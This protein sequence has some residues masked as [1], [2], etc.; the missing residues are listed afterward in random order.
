MQY[1]MN[2]WDDLRYFLAISRHRTLKAAGQALRVDQ[3]TMGRRLASLEAG[4]EA[5]LL[6]KRSDGYF[7]TAAGRRILA[8]VELIE[9][10]TFAIDQGIAGK[11]EKVEGVVKIALPGAL[12]ND[13]ILGRL[14]PL[15]QRYPKLELQFL[16]GPDVLNLARR[17]A[18]FALRFVRPTQQELRAKKVC[19]LRLGLYG[20]EEFASRSLAAL[21]FVGLF[22]AATTQ[23]EA[24]FRESLGF[25]PRYQMRT[26]SWESVRVGLESGAGIG[27]LPTFMAAKNAR[28]TCL[29]PCAQEAPLWL[30]VHPEVAKSARVRATLEF[31][32]KILLEPGEAR[33]T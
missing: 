32:E 30:V 19:S 4:L 3:A 23:L 1:C 9:E 28:L 6:E 15:L 33:S 8:S 29:A 20:L 22:P 5:K 31:L 7:L 11:N 18:D 14:R 2:N 10:T 13:L 21:P 17:E 26:G 16:M 12:A 25:A 27:I 24:D